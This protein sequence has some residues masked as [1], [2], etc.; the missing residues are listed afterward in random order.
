[1]EWFKSWFETSYYHILYKNRNTEEAADFIQRLVTAIKIP[2]GARA[3]DLACGKGRHSVT[4]AK[5]GFEVTG[6]DLSKNS[7]ESARRH[8]LPNLSF[9]IHDMRK[10][11]DQRFNAVF[12]FFTSFG[13][14]DDLADNLEV[15]KSVSSMLDDDGTFVLDYLNANYAK[16]HLVLTEKKQIEGVDF[17]I[18]RKVEDGFIIKTIAVNDASKEFKGEYQEKVADFSLLDFE[19]LMQKTGM[20]VQTTYGDYDLSPFDAE[21]SPRLILV[22]EKVK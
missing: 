4:L 19:E 10:P 17:E 21:L 12:N 7:I 8:S 13:Y 6:V 15:L 1:M 3:L 22:C 14:F 9:A 20:R 18:T 5:L 11:M 16:R 2:A